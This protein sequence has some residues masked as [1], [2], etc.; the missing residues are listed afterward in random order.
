MNFSGRANK[1]FLS[2][3]GKLGI[4]FRPAREEL[5]GTYINLDLLILILFF[6]ICLILLKGDV[7][8]D[9]KKK[10]QKSRSIRTE[11]Y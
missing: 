5:F 10:K 8:K 1:E 7:T 3:R 2:G 9:E 6:S 4:I 11:N